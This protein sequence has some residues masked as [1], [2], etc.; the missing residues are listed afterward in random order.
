MAALEPLSVKMVI[1]Y[2]NIHLTAHDNFAP[3]N[4]QKHESLVHPLRF[5]NQWLQLRT[6][7]RATSAMEAG[8]PVAQLRLDK[9]AVYRGLPSN[10]ENPDGYR[11]NLAQQSEWTRDR[12]VEVFHRPLKYNWVHNA[13]VAQEKGVDVLVALDFVRSADRHEADVL[14]LASHDS[15][16][17]PALAAALESEDC[18]IE[19][20]GWHGSRVLK[21]PNQ[22]IWHAALHAPAFVAS[23]DRRDYK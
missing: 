5:A 7:I 18:V 21:V 16:M 9:V 8:V 22:K 4:V 10:K 19:T 13:R 6:H 23:R 17:E 11:R 14:V 1:D 12:R 3:G 15:D 2:Q 20:V